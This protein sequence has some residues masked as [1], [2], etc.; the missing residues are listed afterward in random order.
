[1]ITRPTAFRLPRERKVHD[2]RARSSRPGINHSMPVKQRNA[3]ERKVQDTNVIIFGFTDNKY[4]AL[5]PASYEARQDG[6]LLGVWEREEDLRNLPIHNP[7]VLSQRSIKTSACKISRY[8]S[9]RAPR[10]ILNVRCR[11]LH[12]NDTTIVL[13]EQADGMDEDLGVWMCPGLTSIAD[14][15]Y[16]ILKHK[17]TPWPCLSRKGTCRKAQEAPWRSWSRWWFAPPQVPPF[18]DWFLD[19]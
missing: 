7:L 3:R 18:F 1:M 16:P 12:V 4:L 19:I 15:A 11:G 17:K 10:S 6:H 2:V 8:V 9:P 13:R 14:N 5:E